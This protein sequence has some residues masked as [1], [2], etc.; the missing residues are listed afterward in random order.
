[1]PVAANF[2]ARAN[3][4]LFATVN[5]IISVTAKMAIHFVP[6]RN[7]A[8]ADVSE[9][10]CK[11]DAQITIYIGYENNSITHVRGG[12]CEESFLFTFIVRVFCLYHESVN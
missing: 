10:I 9:F 5:V 4:E 12:C 3:D 7:C 11:L 8:A 2:R 6:P 1:M